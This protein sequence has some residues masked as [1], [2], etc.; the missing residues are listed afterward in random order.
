[1]ISIQKYNSSQ[2]HILQ[3]MIEELTDY[4]IDIDPLKRCRRLPEYSQNYTN[5]L[6][7]K[8]KRKNGQILFA[9]S[10]FQIVGFI[11]GIIEKQTK[12]DLLECIPT[13]TGRIM[14]LY[15]KPTFRNQNIGKKLMTEMETY[16][17]QKKCTIFK[18]EVFAPNSGAH[19]FYQK[20]DYQERIIDLIKVVS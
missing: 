3:K 10:N 16:F 1:M 8:V 14:E 7:Q 18:V 4:I 15:V 2:N 11:A 20:L 19:Q 9:A 12:E 5:K 6:L 13:K 17:K